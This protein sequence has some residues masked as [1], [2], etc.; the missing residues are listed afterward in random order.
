MKILAIIPARGGSKGVSNKNIKLLGGKPLLQ[1]TYESVLKCKMLYKTILSS[2]D[3]AII[4]VAK[5]IGLDVPFVRPVELSTDTA[6]SISVVQHAVQFL[7]Q[8]GE[9]YDAICLLQP[10]SPFRELSFIDRAIEKFLDLEADSLVS[11]LPVPSQYNPHWTF[12]SDENNF[13]KFSTGVEN[14]IGR[15]QDLPPAFHRDGSLYLT[16]IEYIKQGTFYGNKIGYIESNPEL[17]INIDTLSDWKRAEN[18]LVENL[19]KTNI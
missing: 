4:K 7:E 16:K 17:N 15:R 2:E 11:V 10:T 18:I 8:Q 12:E 1:Y 19:L 6:S 3:R 9:S 5:S 14:I 13:L